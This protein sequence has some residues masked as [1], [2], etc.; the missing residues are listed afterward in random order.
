MSGLT[1]KDLSFKFM[2]VLPQ[3]NR[4]DSTGAGSRSQRRGRVKYS[5]IPHPYQARSGKEEDHKR[6]YGR[7]NSNTDDDTTIFTV[8]KTTPE[9]SLA[10]AIA[11]RAREGKL[12]VLTALGQQA[13]N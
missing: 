3:K 6:E 10:G 7:G 5:G 12:P 4:N 13:V 8:V 9:K 1:S 11:H 2:I